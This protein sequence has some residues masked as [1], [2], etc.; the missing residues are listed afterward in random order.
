M[1]TGN[2]EFGVIEHLRVGHLFSFSDAS[3]QVEKLKAEMKSRFGKH[4]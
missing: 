2:D 3:W 4:Q 1:D